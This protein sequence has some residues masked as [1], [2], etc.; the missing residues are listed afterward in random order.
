MVPLRGTVILTPFIIHAMRESPMS[1]TPFE[2]TSRKLEQFFFMHDIH[3]NGFYKNMDGMT[4]WMY[5]LDAEGLRV[6]EEYRRII[7][8]R[9]QRKEHAGK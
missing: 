7:A 6:Q 1:K 9:N 5:S 8:R 4:V 2:T 3:H